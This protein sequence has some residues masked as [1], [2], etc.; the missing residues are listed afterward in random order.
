[1]Q[2][3]ISVV[4]T[5]GYITV[6]VTKSGEVAGLTEPTLVDEIVYSEIFEYIERPDD[7]L[8][9]K[10]SCKIDG[11]DIVVIK[12]SEFDE[13]PVT[14]Q[15]RFYTRAGRQNN[16]LKPPDVRDKIRDILENSEETS[17]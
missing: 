12:V 6:G 15:G 16:I 10:T 4:D 14:V 2:W 8:L 7:L 17:G 11:D 9:R 1:M 5:S 13:L 3:Q